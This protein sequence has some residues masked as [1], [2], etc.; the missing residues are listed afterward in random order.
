MNYAALLSTA[1]FLFSINSNAT[2]VKCDLTSLGDNSFISID[3]DNRGVNSIEIHH[4]SVQKIYSRWPAVRG[5]FTVDYCNPNDNE[6]RDYS[7]S[8]SLYSVCT[9]SQQP[10]GSVVF[11][12]DFTIEKGGTI[13]F[14]RND[15]TPQN[16]TFS[17]CN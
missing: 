10:V 13:Y 4:Q 7:K 9:S 12:A 5:A 11:Q 16:I 14:L 1:L 17:K 8:Y 15:R 3:L 6:F 2:I